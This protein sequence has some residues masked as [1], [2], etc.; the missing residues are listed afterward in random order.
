[1]AARSAV[2]C[3]IG[4]A[5]VVAIVFVI[6]VLESSTAG[7]QPTMHGPL[8]VLARTPKDGGFLD[9]KQHLEEHWQEKIERAVSFVTGAVVTVD[10]TVSPEISYREHSITYDDRPIIAETESKNTSRESGENRPGVVGNSSRSAEEAPY[11]REEMSEESVV[12][13]TPSIERTIER[14]PFV[15]ERVRVLISAPRSYLRRLLAV[16]RD[17][18]EQGE[19]GVERLEAEVTAE[20]ETIGVALIPPPPQGEDA[21]P[22]VRVV[23]YDDVAQMKQTLK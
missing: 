15:P 18:Q 22:N 2:V 9:A 13:V 7:P 3:V 14:A 16:R 10:V 5:M 12:N 17:G 6:S 4:C 23:W 11:E 21:Y 1:M 20:I 8:P 19:D